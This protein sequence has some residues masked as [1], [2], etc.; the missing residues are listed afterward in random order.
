VIEAMLTGLPV[1]ASNIA[2]PREQVVDGETGFL[3]PV[4]Q[5][6]P[7]AAVLRQLTQDP[8][9]RARMGAAGRERALDRFSE[10]KIL[11][12]TVALLGL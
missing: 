4:R 8:A 5:V 2:G 6:E 12:R 3:V 11:A 9:L 10:P 1:V 7:L